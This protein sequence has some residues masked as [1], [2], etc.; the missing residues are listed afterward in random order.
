MFSGVLGAL[1]LVLAAHTAW[2]LVG[3]E[4]GGY[5]LQL[6]DRTTVRVLFSYKISP[7]PPSESQATSSGYVLFEDAN[8]NRLE[9]KCTRKESGAAWNLFVSPQSPDRVD[10]WAE[11]GPKD[12]E[13]PMETIAIVNG[14]RFRGLVRGRHQ[15]DFE[16]FRTALA[17]ELAKTSEGFRKSLDALY[18]LATGGVDICT[19]WMGFGLLLAPS[20]HPRILSVRRMAASEEKEFQSRFPR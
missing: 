9:M 6:S 19:R 16:E 12:G 13:K 3:V 1:C 14:K 20:L 4:N 5:V 8:L 2:A 10:V 15:T 11:E 17:P 7:S 18:G